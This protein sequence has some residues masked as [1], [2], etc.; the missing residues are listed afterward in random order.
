MSSDL[1]Y[2]AN[3]FLKLSGRIAV[4]QYNKQIYEILKKVITFR[5][6]NAFYQLESG[7][8]KYL[9]SVIF[10]F[11]GKEYPLKIKVVCD[12]FIPIEAGVDLT[13]KHP[14]L[15]VNLYSFKYIEHKYSNKLS[16]AL[17]PIITH[18]VTHFIDYLY[19]PLSAKIVEH[20]EMIADGF[21]K[22]FMT[23]FHTYEGVVRYDDLNTFRGKNIE[24][25]AKQTLF[26]F[27][28]TK[29][30]KYEFGTLLTKYDLKL[31]PDLFGQLLK[32]VQTLFLEDLVHYRDTGGDMF[33][34]SKNNDPEIIK[35][36][37]VA[38]KL[39]YRSDAEMKAYTNHIITEINDKLILDPFLMQFI[40]GKTSITNN[41]DKLLARSPTYE[42]IAEHLLPEQLNHLYKEIAIYL[43][44]TYSKPTTKNWAAKRNIPDFSPKDDL[45]YRYIKRLVNTNPDKLHKLI[46]DEQFRNDNMKAL[47]LFK[48]DLDTDAALTRAMNAMPKVTD[49]ISSTPE[50]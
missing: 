27:L 7:T 50:D 26:K 23:L 8:E 3:Q 13:V 30:Y 21:Y 19:D 22:E 17:L 16:D 41:L 49:P 6:S 38:T 37:D 11:G 15:V 39:Y 43:T 46:Q 32:L 5:D 18:E 42:R 47:M 1:L 36:K 34:I 31:T 10:P 35:T 28:K 44:K 25:V 48:D 24:Q 45:S 33:G 4:E 14:W 2:Q 12:K 29:P 9:E 40:K 20:E